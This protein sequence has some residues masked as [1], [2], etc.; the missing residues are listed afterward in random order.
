MM[1][2]QFLK[3]NLIDGYQNGSF[4]K[5]QVNIYSTNYLLNGRI[6][7]ADFDEIQ[8]VLNPEENHEEV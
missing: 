2:N 7:Q 8:A 4:T 3:Q 5:E 6:T 1:L